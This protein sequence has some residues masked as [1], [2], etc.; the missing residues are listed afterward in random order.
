MS[1]LTHLKRLY[2]KEQ[3]R[4]V[5][6]GFNWEYQTKSGWTAGWRSCLAPK[7]DGDDETCVARFF[8]YKPQAP[9]EEV[10]F[11]LTGA[12]VL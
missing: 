12:Y 5:R 2:P 10:F 8:V 6:H 7:Y 1:I 11:H 4:A 9:T 3:W